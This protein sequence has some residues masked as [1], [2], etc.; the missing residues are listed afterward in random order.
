[1]VVVICGGVSVG[2]HDHVRAGLGALG[3]R[4]TFWGLALKPGRPTWFGT[5]DGVPV[6]GLPGNP[7][8]AFVTCLL[9]VRPALRALQGAPPDPLGAE[10]ILDFRYDKPR[11]R[12]HAL[13][14]RLRRAAD[15]WHVTLTGAQGSHVLS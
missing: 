12:A 7:V 5:L 4:Q 13:R 11:G 15:G 1:D 14:C 2:E 10:A 9:L 3:A 6:F 8:S